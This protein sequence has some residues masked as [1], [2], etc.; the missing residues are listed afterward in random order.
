MKTRA[1]RQGTLGDNAVSQCLRSVVMGDSMRDV[2]LLR[3]RVLNV[4][5]HELRTPV[6]TLSGLSA[7]LEQCTDDERRRE[8][9]AAIARNAQRLEGLLDDLLLAAGISTVVPVE[10]PRPVDLAAEVGAQWPDPAP[11]VSGGA[12]AIARPASVRRALGALVDNAVHHGEAPFTVTASTTDDRAVL[13]IGSGGPEF[14]TADLEAAAE[15]FFRGERAVTEHAG[16]GVGLSVART[17]LEADGGT[18]ALRPRDG[19]GVIVRIEL[20]SA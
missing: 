18:L 8:L 4:V 10:E 9:V 2:D 19:G 1:R 16:L 12:T 15:L 7:A 6:T 17:L 13:E 5:G 20:P 3:R 11:P 14:T